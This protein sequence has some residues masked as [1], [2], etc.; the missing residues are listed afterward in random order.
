MDAKQ[1]AEFLKVFTETVK[2]TP[3][4]TAPAPTSSVSLVANFE[5]YIETAESFQQYVERYENFC[6]IKGITD[7]NIKKRTFLNA[8]GASLY[9]KSKCL[10][11]PKTLDESAFKDIVKVLAEN[12][13][14]TINKLVSQH[15]LL[16]RVQG[17]ESISSFVSDLQRLIVDC[18][19]DCEC[20][21]SVS[22]LL[23]RAQFIRGLNSNSIREQ[24][25]LED[26]DFQKIVNKA[27]V[28]EASKLNANE[29]GSSNHLPVQST[30][31][32]SRFNQN[33]HS[34]SR[35]RTGSKRRSISRSRPRVNYKELG[36]DDLCVRCGRNNHRVNDCK[37][38]ISKLKCHSCQK[39]GHVSKVCIS[40]LIK[41]K[42]SN[43]N[44]SRNNQRVLHLSNSPTYQDFH[45]MCDLDG[46]CHL[47][48]IDLFSTNLYTEKYE[49]DIS[50]AGKSIKFEVDSGSGY[51]LMPISQF[52][53]LNINVPL[54]P[55][56]VKFR[57]YDSGIVVPKGMA[58]VPVKYKNIESKEQ[59]FVVPDG[60]SPL[61]GRTW[62]RKLNISLQ[63]I[64]RDK[65]SSLN[66]PEIFQVKSI[67]EYEK[68][69]PQIF[70]QRVGKIPGVKCSLQ[71]RNNA[72]PTFIKA[73]NLP[74]AIK[75][76][77]E[78]ELAALQEDDIITP[79]EKSDWGSPL[80]PVPK[81]DG[82][83][84][85]CV[86]YK[87]AV[88]AQLTDAHYPIPRIDEVIN[89]FK[90]SKYFC[91][92]DL[93]KAYLHIEVD[94]ESSKIQTIS[95]HQGTYKMKRLSF[96]IKT[97]PS[98]FH[99]IMDQ[100]LQGLEGV[101]S[102]F[103]DIIVH[104]ET[105]FK[106]EEN[107][108]KCFKRLE[109]NDLHLNKSKCSFFQTKISYLGYLV[110]HK[111]IA[112]DP[113]KVEAILEAPRPTDER[114]V[115]TFL[116]LI[117]YYSK[118]IPNH[119]TLTAPIRR[120]LTTNSKFFW[121][122]ECE[123][124]FIKLKNIIASNQTLV[125]YDPDLPV[126]VACDASP[127]GISAVM[128]HMVNGEE[129]PICFVS[130]S[131]SKAEQN[132][133]Q[134]DREALAIVF[135][136]D[137]LYTY[138][139]GRKFT[140]IT[141]N[142]PISRIFH[143]HANIPPITAARL[144]RY[145][146]YLSNFNYEIVHKS[147]EQNANADYFSRNPVKTGDDLPSGNQILLDEELFQLQAE[148]LSYLST[149]VTSTSIAQHT[150]DDPELSKIIQNINSGTSNL[151]DFTLQG[152][153][154]YRDNRVCIP[155]IFQSKI[156]NE[157][158][159]THP[160]IVKMKQLARKYCYWHNIDKDIE[161]LVRTCT[162]CI[163]NQKSPT[164][165]PTHH[166]EQPK[167]N[168]SRVHIDYAGPKDGNFFLIVVDAKSK[169]P[170]I[171]VIKKSPDT[172]VTIKLLEEIF[173][174]HGYPEILTSD[175]ATIFKNA[176]FSDYCT[177]IGI[178]QIFI[179]PGHPATNGLAERYVQILK[180]KLDK[181]S[182]EPVPIIEKV[183][184]IV[185][186]FRA[187]PLA[188]GK[189]PGELYLNRHFRIRLDAIKPLSKPPSSVS[190]NNK[191][192]SLNVGDW[193][194]ARIYINNK[195]SWQLGR[196]LEKFGYL[197]Y[198]IELNNGYEFKRHIDQL[199]RVEYAPPIPVPQ[200]GTQKRVHFKLPNTSKPQ[201]D[202]VVTFAQT[203]PVPPIQATPVHQPPVLE[204]PRRS[205]RE[206]RAPQRFGDYIM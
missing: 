130:R 107:L 26:L 67:D 16:N 35:T 164:R 105:M 45:S 171:K 95:T 77:V 99:R 179:A 69:F 14:P 48:I 27:L 49:V 149:A 44:S 31:H 54:K 124:A 39:Q 34:H 102:Y 118:F 43:S 154:L 18:K 199:K 88:N 37:V 23:L 205:A 140:L 46:V 53:T 189:S 6:V 104:G 5:A 204:S 29:V 76:A 150:P 143:H 176:S 74:F 75:P 122:T 21:K 41:N 180:S 38:N 125:P 100:V 40:T 114:Q 206:H 96:G 139:Y 2:P 8:I 148:T 42:S 185:Q 191:I 157:L 17:N 165:A 162:S 91:K 152:N 79:V 60:L 87:V 184:S 202:I 98:E 144:M 3:S 117:T 12:I 72:R 109:E 59:V 82:K 10:L 7:G 169:W 151:E 195:P 182:N 55:A 187:T 119:S 128:S 47:E 158:H 94:E 188:C 56:T 80:V 155:K 4:T 116:G 64:D 120:L 153:I 78:K 167:E 93:Y 201:D 71:L 13:S 141:D 132:Y 19:F 20:G 85:L 97:A 200:S 170:E 129:K 22:N 134:L 83:V 9:E 58:Y 159:L 106:C 136:L 194:T 172:T 163:L 101:C 178:L 24:L 89:N 181:M 84:R 111:K 173:S 30:H 177:R 90:N 135:A 121:S 142:R 33:Q 147:G 123:L 11:A 192:R 70:Q 168:W 86:D 113:K 112:K 146:A 73:R 131:L 66:Q 133:S 186:I 115:K 193:V 166:W 183:Q 175:N 68:L 36:I 32:I 57:T 156:L 196:V 81:P 197:H 51:T 127:V 203:P 50:I 108:L 63:E 190:N 92:I 161:R 198:Q 1:F 160:G 174:S 65:P 137:R 52:K 25:L 61:L 138:L 103:D 28:L 15:R 126:V 62:I 145:A 110:S